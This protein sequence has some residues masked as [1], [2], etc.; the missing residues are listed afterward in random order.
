MTLHREP[1]AYSQH[2]VGAGVMTQT[3]AIRG[4]A[5]GNRRAG[6]CD[7]PTVHITSPGRLSRMQRP[8]ATEHF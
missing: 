4:A 1:Y 8:A 5:V 7:N 6:V 3:D 2:G